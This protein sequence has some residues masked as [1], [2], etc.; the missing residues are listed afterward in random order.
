MRTRNAFTLIELLVSV[1]ITA[2]VSAVMIMSPAAARQTA[3][4]EAEK[5]Y[6]YVYR[7]MHRADKMHRSFY[8]NIGI[9]FIATKWAGTDYFDIEKSYKATTGCTYDHNYEYGTKCEYNPNTKMF[10]P[11]HIKITDADGDKWYVIFAGITEGRVR[12]SDSPP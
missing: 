8:F 11:G 3:K 1:V 10:K 2:I 12:I 7:Q 6:A 4:R 9:N 5:L